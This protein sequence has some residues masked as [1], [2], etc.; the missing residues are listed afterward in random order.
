[1]RGTSSVVRFFADS[2]FA[3]ACNFL[4]S[5]KS[6]SSIGINSPFVSSMRHSDSNFDS[7]FNAC[8]DSDFELFAHFH[9]YA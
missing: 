8:E 1:M 7:D 9:L 5:E 2:Y 6:N 3:S 4:Y